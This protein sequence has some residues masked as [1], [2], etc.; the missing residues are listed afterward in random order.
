MFKPH[1]RRNPE[2]V[3]PEHWGV[4][5]TGDHFVAKNDM[6]VGYEGSQYGCVLFDLGSGGLNLYP[7]AKHDVETMV[8]A[9]KNYEG[10]RPD[11]NVSKVQQFRCDNAPELLAGS[12]RM[13][14][15]TS[16]STPF[17]K[18]TNAMAERSVRTLEEGTETALEHA[19]HSARF[20]PLAGLHFCA[21][22]N[23]RPS[24]SR[25]NKCPYEIRHGSPIPY[26]LVP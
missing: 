2:R 19:G 11:P 1:S 22:W 23:A 21:M 3:L 18:E 15:I 6:S 10:P 13:G 14:W 20:W 25:K 12:R 24:K 17:F 7:T 4:Q 8:A 16:E 5:V 9:F 26:V